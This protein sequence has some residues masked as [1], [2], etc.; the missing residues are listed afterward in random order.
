MGTD[1]NMLFAFSLAQGGEFAFVL[2]SFSAQ[3]AVLPPG[4]IQPLVAAVAVSMAATPLLMLTNEKW[5]QPRFGT[6]TEEK[7]Q[8]DQINEENRVI[9]AGF[10]RFGNIVGRFL[11]ANGVRATFLDLDADNVEVL[12]KLGIKVFYGD[13][14][15]LDLLEAAGAR[16]A[17]L[18]I[19]AIDDQQKIQAIVASVQKH[20]PDLA[21]MARA[22]SR[23]E[24]YELLES[25]VKHVYRETFDTS[26]RLAI[27]ALRLLG[28]H[29]YHAHRMAR[30]FRKKDEDDLRELGQMRHD[31]KAYLSSARERIADL[32]RLLMDEAEGHDETRDMGWDTAS[33]REDIAK[34][35][36]SD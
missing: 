10:G 20:Y 30:M 4:I 13:T 18:L 6:K 19:L 31:R 8:P 27:E 26:L 9:V 28:V 1:N 7:A 25:G 15:R 24:A 3:H 35:T 29:P 32:E 16:H 11:R 33:L 34:M 23:I 12:R 2:F 36:T 14:S 21:I 22:N 5:I 17:D